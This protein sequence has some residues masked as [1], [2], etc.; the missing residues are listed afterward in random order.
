VLKELFMLYVRKPF[1]VSVVLLAL[2][3]P[4]GLFGCSHEVAHTETTK[5]NWTGG[6]THDE[7]TV[8]KNPDGS[9]SVDKERQVTH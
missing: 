1:S 4:F 8:Y 9:V 2:A 7:T 6:Q 3:C 5:N